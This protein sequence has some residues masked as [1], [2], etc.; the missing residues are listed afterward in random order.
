VSTELQK[1]ILDLLLKIHEME[2]QNIENT[3]QLYIKDSLISQ[4]DI[5]IARYMD[6]KLIADHIIS[7]Q[8]ALLQGQFT[9]GSSHQLIV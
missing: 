4:K 1:E 5:I 8:R 9:S 6:Y 7:Q 3:S 2:I